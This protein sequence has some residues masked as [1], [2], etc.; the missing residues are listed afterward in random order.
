MLPEETER[1]VRLASFPDLPREYEEVKLRNVAA[2]CDALEHNGVS[3]RSIR[4]LLDE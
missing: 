1:A 3:A 4:S 2:F